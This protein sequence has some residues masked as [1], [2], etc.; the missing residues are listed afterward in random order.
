VAFALSRLAPG[1]RAGYVQTAGGALAGWLS[2]TVDALLERGM[3]VDHVTAGPCH[4]GGLESVTVEGAMDAGKQ[5]LGW[6]CAILGPGP[7]ILGSASALGHGGL[8]AL[9]NAHAAMAVG[10][11]ALVLV[12]RL[13]SGDPRERHRGLSHHTE[14]V[15]K[16]LLAPVTVPLAEGLTPVGEGALAGAASGPTAHLV[17]RV[18]ATRLLEEYR[19]SGLPATTMGRPLDQDRDFFLAGLAGG[20]VLARHASHWRKSRDV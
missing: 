17:E 20:A 18:D 5:A 7:G 9:T 8:A 19:A 15:L 3:L 16:L 12:P 4:G 1:L 10:C 6:D 13:S 14:T 2:D 11:H